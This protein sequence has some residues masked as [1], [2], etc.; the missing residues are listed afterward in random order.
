[1]RPASPVPTL[2]A[3]PR[4]S[5]FFQGVGVLGRAFRL[6]FRSRR[7]FLL[8]SLCAVLTAVTL[9]GLAVV[10]YRYAPALLESVWPQPGSWYGRA[11]WTLAL[12]LGA[13]V[14]WVVGANVVPPLL[15]TPLQDPL[16]E[17]TEAACARTDA[18]RSPASFLRGL[19]TGLLHTLA[20]M[21]L[22]LL[23][24]AIL[25]PLN[26]V[27]G[28][29]SVAFTVLASVWTMLWMAAEHLATPMTRHLYPFAE[30]RRMLRE[31]RALCL[32]FGAGVYVLLWVP[33][34]NTFFL[35]V[36]IVGGTLLYRGLRE[37]GDLPPPPDAVGPGGAPPG[38][39]G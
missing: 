25:L 26:L 21:A 4:L 23:G 37:A 16:S 24:L 2:S 8:S 11:G 32:G 6:L 38:G 9:V 35:P 36:A 31:R 22:L 19:T 10:L 20:R 30:V 27:P 28:A 7:L 13:L 3:R 39:R 1:M 34:L 5:D 29:G 18:V 12:V 33:I 14:A 15:L 17:A